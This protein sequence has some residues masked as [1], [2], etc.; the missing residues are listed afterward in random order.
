MNATCLLPEEYAHFPEVRLQGRR[1]YQLQRATHSKPGDTLH[2]IIIGE[3][4]FSATVHHASKEEI[5]AQCEEILPLLPRLPLAAIVAAARP[6]TMKRVIQFVVQ[7]GVQS[8]TIVSAEQ[9]EASYLDS[10]LLTPEG[11][12]DEVR[13]GLEQAFDATPPAITVHHS[14]RETFFAPGERLFGSLRGEFLKRFEGSGEMVTIAIG[15]EKGW[16]GDE[17]TFLCQSDFKPISLGARVM[18]VDVAL[19]A[20]CGG[21][22]VGGAR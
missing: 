13:A 12:Q 7:A 8:L 11:I 2:F 9:T 17:E 4:R 5:V 6:P 19:A 14:L 20:L 10:H 16:S 15:P 21:F 1:A 22:V 18:R 3:R